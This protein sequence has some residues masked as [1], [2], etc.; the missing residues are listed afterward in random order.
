M[1]SLASIVATEN[2]D[3]QFREAVEIGGAFEPG[4][5][6]STIHEIVILGTGGGSAVTGGLLRSFL[7]NQLSQPIVICQGYNIPA[8]IDEH[9]LV[10]VMSHSGNTEEILCMYDQ[11]K[12]KGAHLISITSGGTLL[13]RSRQDGVESLVV[14][15]DIGH[16]RR[17]LGYLFVTAVILLHKLGL[18]DDKTSELEGV[19]DLFALLREKYRPEIPSERNLAKQIAFRL[20]WRIPV[21]YGSSDYYDSVAWRWKNQFGE[22]SK[23]MSFYNVIPNIHHDEAVGWEA[24]D[25]IM[26][27]FHFIILRDNEL[28]RVEVKKRKDVTAKM[29]K[30]KQAGITE[31]DAEGVG[32]LARMFSLIYLGDFVSLYASICRGI[33]PTPVGIINLF[34]KEMAEWSK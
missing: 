20:A 32:V 10:L 28:D 7:F 26:R 31:V 18:I 8:Y 13:A 25:E 14:P 9:S 16:P 29:L 19:A 11:A 21:I 23:Q 30:Q 33:D 22:N 2:Y 3:L 27:N 5:P 6:G 12:A 4:R 34:K 15:C 17:D 1:D 24:P